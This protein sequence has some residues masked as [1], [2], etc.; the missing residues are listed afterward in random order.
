MKNINRISVILILFTF[1]NIY[2]NEDKYSL[3]IILDND[4]FSIG[5]N[6]DRYYTYGTELNLTFPKE[7]SPYFF[8]NDF[9]FSLDTASERFS[10]ALTHKF[11]TPSNISSDTIL[12][13]DRPYSGLFYLSLSKISANYVKSQ[14][15]LSHLSIGFIGP[16]ALGKELQTFLHK[17]WFKSPLPNGWENQISNDIVLNFYNRFENDLFYR[18][19]PEFIKTSVLLDINA[20]TL[21]NE[22]GLGANFK[23][24]RFYDLHILK[25]KTTSIAYQIY[26]DSFIRFVVYNSLLQGGIF[27]KNSVHTITADNVNRFYFNGEFGLKLNFYDFEIDYSNSIRTPEFNGGKNVFWASLKLRFSF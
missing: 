9:L 3:Q 7:K 4:A 18:D 23:I 20:G 16:I 12:K 26:F 19:I 5:K 27:N 1:L 11:F 17:K 15:L 2:G 13:D 24:G 10:F 22:I 6:Y 25:D 14:R 21:L 8:I